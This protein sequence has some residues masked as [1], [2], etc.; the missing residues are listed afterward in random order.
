MSEKG[1][2]IFLVFLNMIIIT[3][4]MLIGI[5]ILLKEDL[6]KSVNLDYETNDFLSNNKK[7]FK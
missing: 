3:V 6:L 1:N 7:Y 5:N 4:I 2:N